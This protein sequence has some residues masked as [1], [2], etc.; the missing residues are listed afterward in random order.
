MSA[1]VLY[2]LQESPVAKPGSCTGKAAL[3]LSPWISPWQI[4]SL[5]CC[6]MIQRGTR[7]AGI[8]AD[9]EM[10]PFPTRVLLLAG[11][12]IW[13]FFASKLRKKSKVKTNKQK[14]LYID[15]KE[16]L[17]NFLTNFLFSLFSS[18]EQENIMTKT[19]WRE[20]YAIWFNIFFARDFGKW[21]RCFRPKFSV[22]WMR[23]KLSLSFALFSSVWVVSPLGCKWCS[24]KHRSLFQLE[25]LWAEFIRRVRKKRSRY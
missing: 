21:L 7:R 5:G 14:N 4:S 13:I 8:I 6:L 15:E 23:M 2:S 24:V 12:F 16:L 1:V 19:F 20:M 17:S 18:L 22:G 25:N 10:L 9:L 3:I 11:R